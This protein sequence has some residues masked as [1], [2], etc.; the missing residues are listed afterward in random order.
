RRRT[1]NGS[2]TP[3]QPAFRRVVPPR[4]TKVDRG[5][6]SHKMV[7]DRFDQASCQHNDYADVAD[8]REFGGMEPTTKRTSPGIGTILTNSFTV[9]N[10][11]PEKKAC[12]GPL[13]SLPCE[14][15][16]FNAASRRD[17][18][19]GR[20]SEPRPSGSD[21]LG[22]AC[23]GKEPIPIGTTKGETARVPQRS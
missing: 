22:G 5:W 17:P 23:S 1:E 10:T 9:C 16:Q 21:R 20:P 2:R 12:R 3:D 15:R 18:T 13:P 4:S 14:R 6:T 8:S 19:Q 11:P 7:K